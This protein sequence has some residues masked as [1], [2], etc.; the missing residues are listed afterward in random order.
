MM[1]NLFERIILNEKFKNSNIN[2]LFLKIGTFCENKLHDTNDKFYSD[3]LKKIKELRE[4]ADEQNFLKYINE[5]ISKFKDLDEETKKLLNELLKNQNNGN[6]KEQEPQKQAI[7]VVEFIK[8]CIQKYHTG[9]KTTES[10]ANMFDISFFFFFYKEID[11]GKDVAFY[12]ID[13]Y[14]KK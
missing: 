4:K 5:N 10:I 11:N 9:T 13:T 12:C 2:Q 7:N 1:M 8:S 3:S 14:T 6:N